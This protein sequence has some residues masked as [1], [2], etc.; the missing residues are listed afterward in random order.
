VTGD[1]VA[2]AIGPLVVVTPGWTDEVYQVYEAELLPLQ[3]PAA[4]QAGIKL[5]LHTWNKNSRPP[6][7]VILE[8]YRSHLPEA[9]KSIGSAPC[10]I[11]R[12]LRVARDAYGVQC[13]QDGREPN[14]DYFDVALAKALTRV[15]AST[16]APPQRDWT[17]P[18]R[19]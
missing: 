6:I 3:H 12:G 15:H 5:L 18:E 7:A 4:L 13:R 10:D 11:E 1:E 9:P 8:A 2:L 14:Y 19:A 16:P 17:E